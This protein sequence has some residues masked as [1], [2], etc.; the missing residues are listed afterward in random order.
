MALPLGP[1]GLGS[2]SD[3]ASST[4]SG[5][6]IELT[7]CGTNA[8]AFFFCEDHTTEV[9]DSSA[10]FQDLGFNP[11][12]VDG[13]GVSV[14]I[15]GILCQHLDGPAKGTPRHSVNAVCVASGDDIRSSLVNGSMDEE[16]GCVC[17]SRHVAWDV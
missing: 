3:L 7:K 8:V 2:W 6:V 14:K 11:H 15:C 1:V 4:L 17:R 10:I 13:L 9:L 12:F 16:S 5:W